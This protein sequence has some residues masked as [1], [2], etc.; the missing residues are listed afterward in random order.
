V[1]SYRFN[2][3]LTMTDDVRREWHRAINRVPDGAYCE[4]DLSPR[5]E[6]NRST[7]ANR[8]YWKN[9]VEP[10]ARFL[11]D[12]EP[13]LADMT[14]AKDVAHY[15]VI[16][17]RILGSTERRL[18][19]GVTVSIPHPTHDMTVD[20]FRD[21]ADRAEVWVMGFI[22]PDRAERSPCRGLSPEGARK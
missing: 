1:S 19:G 21:F 16:V 15:E 11:M 12:Q 13:E 6:L 8:W 10:L 3:T 7:N 9:V 22:D 2:Q 5:R 14:R 4:L 20:Q 17:P 18:S